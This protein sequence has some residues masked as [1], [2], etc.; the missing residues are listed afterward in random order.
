[1]GIYK[2]VFHELHQSVLFLLGY[3]EELINF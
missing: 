1:L 3:G 2:T